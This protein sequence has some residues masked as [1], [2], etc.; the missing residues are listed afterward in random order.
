[1]C[2]GVSMRKGI[3]MVVTTES[4]HLF[5][6]LQVGQTSAGKPKL[7][8]RT[9]PHVDVNA[10]DANILSALSAMAPLFAD[11]VY[12][13]G[14]VDTVSLASPVTT[15]GSGGTSTGTSTSGAGS[16]TASTGTA[17]SGQPVV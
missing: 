6:Q 12:M 5:L 2:I 17:G 4:R 10:T 15:T 9:Y 14:R 7:H 3:H 1:M 11:P 16:S 8:N 13:M